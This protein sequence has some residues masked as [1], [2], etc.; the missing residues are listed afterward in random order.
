VAEAEFLLDDFLIF[1]VPAERLIEKHSCGYSH[2]VTNEWIVEGDLA[3]FHVAEQP[4]GPVRIDSADIVRSLQVRTRYLSLQV[5]T[6]REGNEWMMSVLFS[7][8]VSMISPATH[9]K[10]RQPV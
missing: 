6:T 8:T 4:H 7:Y 10:Q 3:L 2:K 9:S 1:A 5:T